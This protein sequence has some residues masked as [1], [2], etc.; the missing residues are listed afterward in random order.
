MSLSLKWFRHQ[1]CFFWLKTNFLFLAIFV[2]LQ[3]LENVETEIKCQ[4]FYFFHF[5]TGTC[6]LGEMKA[7]GNIAAILDCDSESGLTCIG[8]A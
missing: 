4:D 2:S 5:F 8:R 6:F 7:Q 3:F 1:S